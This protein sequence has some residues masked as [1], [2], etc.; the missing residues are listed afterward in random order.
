MALGFEPVGVLRRVARDVALRRYRSAEIFGR[1]RAWRQSVRRQP[2]LIYQMGKVASTTIEASLQRAEVQPFFKVHSLREPKLAAERQ[3][4][5]SRWQPDAGGW[6]I[7]ESIRA[8]HLVDRRNGQWT[9]ISLVRDPVARNLSAFFQVAEFRHGIPLAY[10]D[11]HVDA[12]WVVDV[13]V[14][15]FLGTYAGHHEPATWFQEELEAVFGID[16]YAT[17]FDKGR[18]FSSYVTDRANVVVIRMEDLRDVFADAMRVVLPGR[19]IPIV[20]ANRGET[21]S[22]AELYRR[23]REEAVLPS[24]YLDELYRS[25]YARHFYTDAEIARFRGA[26][27][28][29][30]TSSDGGR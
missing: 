6:H 21:K 2:V 5:A 3:A 14:D 20:S 28:A 4:Y 23:V 15:E 9:V 25:R 30:S 12:P 13:L 7:W 8:Q 16:V 18:G 26:W 24:A 22:Y 17:P 27:T 11:R 29:R 1:F 19:E 10:L